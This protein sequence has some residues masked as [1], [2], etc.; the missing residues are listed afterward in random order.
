MSPKTLAHGFFFTIIFP[1]MHKNSIVIGWM[2][3]QFEYLTG[4]IQ[5]Q[6]LKMMTLVL[7]SNHLVKACQH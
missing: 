4:L 3:E 2:S 7:M 6:K 1:I 5:G